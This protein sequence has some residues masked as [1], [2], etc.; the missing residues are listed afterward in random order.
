MPHQYATPRALALH[1]QQT[2]LQES[3]QNLSYEELKET[4]GAYILI[5]RNNGQTVE[6]GPSSQEEFTAFKDS[7]DSNAN[8]YIFVNEETFKSITT[9]GCATTTKKSLGVLACAVLS[10]LKGTAAPILIL[11]KGVSDIPKDAASAALFLL[12]SSAEFLYQKWE[13]IDRLDGKPDVNSHA[14]SN[15]QLPPWITATLLL[16]AVS[17]GVLALAAGIIGTAKYREEDSFIATAALGFSVL[18]GVFEFLQ[19]VYC[20]LPSAFESPAKNH[21]KP[22]ASFANQDNRIVKFLFHPTVARYVGIA[23]REIYPAATT[24]LHTTATHELLSKRLP[25]FVNDITSIT[26]GSIAGNVIVGY[27][28]RKLVSNLAAKGIILDHRP[29]FTQVAPMTAE[30]S[31]RNTGKAAR[32][33][34]TYPLYASYLK[35]LHNNGLVSTETLAKIKAAGN[36]F[37]LTTLSIRGSEVISCLTV[38]GKHCGSLPHIFGL[39]R[40]T[41]K[42]SIGINTVSTA[43]AA[44]HSISQLRTLEQSADSSKEET[45]KAAQREEDLNELGIKTSCCQ[46]TSTVDL[47]IAVRKAQDNTLGMQLRS[48]TA[49]PT[50]TTHRRRRTGGNACSRFFA[51]LFG[52]GRQ[53]PP[54]MVVNSKETYRALPGGSDVPQQPGATLAVDPTAT[55]HNTV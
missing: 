15:E 41:P 33:L 48:S 53:Q 1:P 51:G 29:W 16:Y 21:G 2:Q 55:Q 28:N 19:K 38:N 14:P 31:C 34:V 23:V 6:T 3:L 47:M 45:Q 50:S 44:L 52:C 36:A 10:A 43:G 46:S 30:F 7:N 8:N 54:Q 25:G 27:D 39:P 26:F 24:A 17:S 18:M 9:T 20:V 11:N 13:V 37:N 42:V 32:K 5:F 22:N 12:F 35:D 40:Y 4:H 49:A